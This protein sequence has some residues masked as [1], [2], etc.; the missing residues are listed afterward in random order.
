[1]KLD[2]ILKVKSTVALFTLKL[3]S[4]SAALLRT[5]CTVATLKPMRRQSQFSG[6][7]DR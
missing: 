5:F 1:M 4:P 7:S 6:R 3:I 2:K